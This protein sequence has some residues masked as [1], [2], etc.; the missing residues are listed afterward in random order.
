MHNIARHRQE[1]G[2]PHLPCWSAVLLLLTSL[3]PALADADATPRTFTVGFA[4][5]T[6]GN[7]WRQAQ[8]EA[9]KQHF[10]SDPAI[11][12]IYTDGH[13][14]TAQQIRDIETL[15]FQKIDVL[16][17]SPRDGVASAPAIAKAYRA[18]I[19]VVLLTRGVPGDQYTTLVAPDD[20]KIGAKAARFMAERLGGKGRILMLRGVPT[21][22]TAQARSKGF[23]DAL[24]PYPHIQV[25]AVKDGNYLRSDAIH[26]T[27]ETLA[28]G[29]RFDAIYAQSDSMAA[30]A[31][32]ALRKAGIDPRK[33][34]IVGI[35]YISEAREAIRDGEQTASFLYP[36]C[37]VEAARAVQDILH[38]K[39]VPRH[40]KVDT[41]MVTRD[42]VEQVDPIF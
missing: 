16:I 32:M 13:G 17:T 40:I 35:D 9:L 15:V 6:L 1:H 18:G 10:R 3:L 38:G 37:A 41:L 20:L 22:T 28:E 4:Q 19:P 42:N 25:V 24:K 30:G 23:L 5:D 2:F 8:V 11:R 39:T 33:L 26:A 14:Q 7:D 31:R 29:I 36:T 12:F 27:E 21:A 34:L